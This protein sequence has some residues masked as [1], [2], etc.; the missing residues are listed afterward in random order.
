MRRLAVLLCSAALVVSCS[1]S[2]DSASDASIT[3]TS[4]VETSAAERP[5][6]VFAPSSYSSDTPMPLV[7]LLHGFGASG[8]IQEAYFGSNRWPSNVAFCSCTP[9]APST[10]WACLLYTSPSPRD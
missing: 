8:A 3:S 9:M 4:A 5:F 2:D 6:E 1:S 7:V 10:H